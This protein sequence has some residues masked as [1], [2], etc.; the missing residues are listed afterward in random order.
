MIL[1]ILPTE[2]EASSWMKDNSDLDINTMRLFQSWRSV[3]S[4]LCSCLCL[5]FEVLHPFIKAS[6]KPH[7]SIITLQCKQNSERLHT[8]CIIHL[9][10]TRNS[11]KWSQLNGLLVSMLSSLTELP[12]PI[13]CRGKWKEML[14]ETKQLLFLA[15]FAAYSL[16][17]SSSS[18]SS[19]F[20]SSLAPH[21]TIL[22]FT[23]TYESSLSIS[24]FLSLP[25]FIYHSI[26][27][28]ST[29]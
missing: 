8:V 2:T 26:S 14:G 10:S 4:W 7:Q 13:V 22:R 15:S 27:L 16:S 12:G 23:Y 11:H 29:L 19:S 21:L 28:F 24:I 17:P 6:S 5:R 3:L 9:L 25:S 18:F 20:L 1:G